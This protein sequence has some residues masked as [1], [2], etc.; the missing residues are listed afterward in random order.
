MKSTDYIEKFEINDKEKGSYSV[1]LC[2]ISN[3]I[4]FTAKYYSC[5]YAYVLGDFNYILMV[6]KLREPLL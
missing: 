1:D 2:P 5:I 4:R 3:I 6:K